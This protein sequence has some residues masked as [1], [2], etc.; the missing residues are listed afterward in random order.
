MQGLQL[1][2]HP[3]PNG[4]KT[5]DFISTRFAPHQVTPQPHAVTG[6][7]AAFS[8]PCL[9][10]CS[11]RVAVP[12]DDAVAEAQAQLGDDGMQRVA[13]RRACGLCA[14]AETKG[15]ARGLH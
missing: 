3:V 14:Q 9:L 2:S 8:P 6:P 12:A 15:T 11:R 10:P 13:A 7:R 1:D 5:N 4:E